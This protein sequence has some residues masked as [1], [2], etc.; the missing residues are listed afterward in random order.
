MQAAQRVQTRPGAETSSS[1]AEPHQATAGQGRSGVGLASC[2]W[3]HQEH[4]APPVLRQ[5]ERP[6]RSE[7]TRLRRCG[8][9]STLGL[10]LWAEQLD[11]LCARNLKGSRRAGFMRLHE[12]AP[13][14]GTRSGT[15]HQPRQQDGSSASLAVRAVHA[16]ACPFGVGKH[17]QA[18]AP[19]PMKRFVIWE[20]TC[21]CETSR[22]VSACSASSAGR[23][24]AAASSAHAPCV[25]LSL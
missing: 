23:S 22:N 5:H 8:L 3:G 12:A 20:R 15:L 2:L 13:G 1:W 21:V 19:R 17:S 6:Q 11:N 7:E 18:S 10:G 4:A 14:L 16:R 24:A 9:L 25:L